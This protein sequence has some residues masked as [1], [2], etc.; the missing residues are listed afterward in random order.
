[1]TGATP[2]GEGD[3]RTYELVCGEFRGNEINAA[4]RF[5]ERTSVQSLSRKV[6]MRGPLNCRS[7]GF[8]RDDKKEG[9][10]YR[11]RAVTK[12]EGFDQRGE[13]RRCVLGA[14]Y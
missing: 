7:L 9:A 2:A 14:E 6:S 8:A 11:V 3:K 12:G 13:Y 5:Q 4:C 10:D 1:M